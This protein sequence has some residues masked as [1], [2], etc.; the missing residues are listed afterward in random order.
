MKKLLI[1]STL[2]LSTPIWAQTYIQNARTVNDITS[3]SYQIAPG[4]SISPPMWSRNLG[5]TNTGS[6]TYGNNSTSTNNT[7]NKP[8]SGELNPGIIPVPDNTNG[9]SNV[10]VN[11][12]SASAK[13][14]QVPTATPPVG[15]TAPV[16]TAPVAKTQP[17]VVS[18]PLPKPAIVAGN[19]SNWNRTTQQEIET[20]ANAEL[21]EKYKAFLMQK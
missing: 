12:P 18:K 19:I 2:I 3:S 14:M 16:A 8:S 10:S 9:G 1:L 13:N 21:Q 17:L 7:S 4:V 6:S 11:V 5:N 15:Q 20:K